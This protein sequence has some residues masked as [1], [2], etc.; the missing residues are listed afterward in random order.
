MIIAA[1]ANGEERPRIS[2]H[3]PGPI[4]D[5]K[6]WIPPAAFELFAPTRSTSRCDQQAASYHPSGLSR[7]SGQS[8]EK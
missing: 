5:E 1:V 6:V 7:D 8:T 4:L 2:M 3:L